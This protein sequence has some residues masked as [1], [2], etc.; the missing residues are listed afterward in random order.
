MFTDAAILKKQSYMTLLEKPS[1]NGAIKKM[2]KSPTTP[3]K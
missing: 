3:A 1:T 2:N